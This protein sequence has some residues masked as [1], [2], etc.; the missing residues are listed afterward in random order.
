MALIV[1]IINIVM[2]ILVILGIVPGV[3][4]AWLFLG[5]VI[6]LS[7]SATLTQIVNLSNRR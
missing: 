6:L 7:L 4:F 2:A 3:V 5:G 1:G